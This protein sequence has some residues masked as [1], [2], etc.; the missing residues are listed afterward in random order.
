MTEI[1]A[2][3]I[4]QAQPRGGEDFPG[5]FAMV[6]EEVRRSGRFV[7]HVYACPCGRGTAEVYI[8]DFPGDFEVDREM[9]CAVCA[10]LWRITGAAYG[11]TYTRKSDI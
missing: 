4:A 2:V 9:K 1:P 5:E 3:R 11:A 7:H 8:Y 10:P 6:A